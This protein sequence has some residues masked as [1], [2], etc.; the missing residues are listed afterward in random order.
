MNVNEV[1]SDRAIEILGGGLGSK[2]PV[3]LTDHFN[4]NQS[5]DH[6]FSIG[7]EFFL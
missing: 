3:H 2:I 6:T 1:I 4:K 5:S 7:K